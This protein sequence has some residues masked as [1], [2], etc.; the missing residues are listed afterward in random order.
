MIHVNI[1]GIIVKEKVLKAFHK[2]LGEYP[3]DP[4]NILC[5]IGILLSM[6]VVGM[7]IWLICYIISGI[8]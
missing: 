1:G 3:F 2:I 8:F 4:V 6:I 5:N 7:C